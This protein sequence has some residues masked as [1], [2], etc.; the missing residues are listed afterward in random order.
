MN[1]FHYWVFQLSNIIVNVAI[2]STNSSGVNRDNN[3]IN[4]LFKLYFAYT[5]LNKNINIVTVIIKHIINITKNASLNYKLL[6]FS[7]KSVE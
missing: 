7:I 1:N 4:L 6:L 2:Y 3:A 5:T